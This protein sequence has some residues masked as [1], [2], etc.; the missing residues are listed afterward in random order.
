MFGSDGLASVKSEMKQLHDRKVMRPRFKK[1]LTYQQRAEALSYLMFLKRKRCGKIK[2]RGCAEGRK[3]QGKIPP[4]D[5]TS[6][7]MSTEAV[8]L[9]AMIDALEDHAVAVIDIPGAFMQADIDDE[10]IIRFKGKMTELLIEVDKVLY[11]PYA[12]MEHGKTVIYVDLLKAL[13]GTLKAAR[14]FW[15]KFTTTLTTLGF[16]IN[17]TMPV[18]RI[19]QSTV[20]SA[21]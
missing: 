10:V 19:K 14:L 15:E 17:P 4:E 13:Y 9:T 3:Q 6:P 21:H 18:L 16:Q 12:M 2:A 8:F 20:P 11:R 1:E 5:T 7:T